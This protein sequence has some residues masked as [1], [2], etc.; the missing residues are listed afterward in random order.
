MRLRS[1]IG[2]LG[3]TGRNVSTGLLEVYAG[4]EW[5]TV[6]NDQFTQTSAD[7]VCRQMGY[8]PLNTFGSVTS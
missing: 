3:S 4:G 2:G 1:I 8:S 6:C 5:G 7:F